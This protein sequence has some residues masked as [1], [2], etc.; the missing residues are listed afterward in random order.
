[1]VSGWLWTEPG[2]DEQVVLLWNS[3]LN[4]RPPGLGIPDPCL[5]W[6]MTKDYGTCCLLSLT[7]SF[8]LPNKHQRITIPNQQ[9]WT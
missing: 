3:S 1:M 8:R 7:T 2:P 5:S 9:K 6:A 4:A